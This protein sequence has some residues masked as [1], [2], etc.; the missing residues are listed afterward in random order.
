MQK[1]SKAVAVVLAAVAFAAC[2]SSVQCKGEGDPLNTL[3]DPRNQQL[4]C[5]DRYYRI[6]NTYYTNDTQCQQ[7]ITAAMNTTVPNQC[8]P[9]G[10]APGSAVHLCMNKNGTTVSCSGS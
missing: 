8:P 5:I 2:L 7:L 10:T 4:G 9:G 3:Q 6:L 1:M